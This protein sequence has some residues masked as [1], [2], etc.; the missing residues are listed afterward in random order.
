MITKFKNYLTNHRNA[1]FF[2]LKQ[3]SQ[4]KLSSLMTI[5]VIGIAFSLPCCLWVILKNAKSV[6]QNWQH[7][8]QMSLFLEKS[9]S[10]EQELSLLAKVR[11]YRGV[12]FA[13]YISPSQGLRTLEEQTG[14][15]DVLKKLD[16]NP[17]PAVIEV[18]PSIHQSAAVKG[19]VDEFKRLE[20]VESVKID[21]QWL[22]R[23]DSMVLLASHGAN[24][25]MVLFSLAVVLVVGNTIRLSIQ[26][27]RKEIEVLK[28]IGATNAFI[29]RPFLY[30][31]VLYGFLGALTAWLVVTFLVGWIRSAA[32]HLASLYHA[33]F[34][35]SAMGMVHGI[36]LL[37]IGM[38]LGLI[39]ASIAVS[40]Q[41]RAF[42]PK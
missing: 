30:F 4:A 1:L 16:A 25:L 10:E 26:S 29:R 19:L 5:T 2:S 11:T 21:M 3:F 17:L 6:T 13:N 42:D 27:K 23:L 35:L 31:G 12:S 41:M 40:K 22:E 7:T 34:V 33:D 15:V 32:H 18:H 28:L 14:M 8:M 20:G 39:G 37:L 9:L 36:N 24:A 38:I